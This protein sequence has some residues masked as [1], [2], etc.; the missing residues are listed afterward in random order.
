[1]TI[2]NKICLSLVI[3]FISNLLGNSVSAVSVLPIGG[4]S[5]ETAVLLSPGKYQGGALQGRQELY[6]IVQVKAGQKITAEAR[7][8]SEAGCDLFLFNESKEELMSN[9]G[10]NPKVSWLPNADKSSYNYYFKIANDYADVESFTVEV[11]LTNYY[12]ANSSTD[13]GATFESA[14]NLNTIP[15]S[16]TGYLSKA[17]YDIP[18]I[19]DDD[20]DLYRISVPKGIPYEFKLTP[21]TKGRGT[22][23]LYD[24]TRQLIDEK[25]SPNEGAFIS[26]FLI[27]AANTSVF[28]AVS[29]DWSR[30]LSAYK[31]D[32]KSS[33]PVT[34]FYVCKENYCELAGEYVSL[35]DCQTSTTKTCY[36]TE[37]CDDQC[38][39]PTSTTIVPPTTKPQN[40][41]NLNQTKC[42]DNFNYQKCDNYDKD[43]YLEWST[44]VY[45]GEGNKC[46]G[47]KCVKAKGCQCSAWVN[48]EC[49]RNNCQASEMYQTRTCDPKNCDKEEQCVIDA[50]CK[51]IPACIKNSDCLKG[52]ICKTGECI[53]KGVGWWRWFSLGF[54]G[55]FFW[56]YLILLFGLYIY[57]A[58]C[59]QFLAK[60]TNTPNGWL[61]WI[62]IADIFLMLQ[63]SQKPLWW[64]LLF[65]IPIVNI[66]IGIIIWMKIAE[67]VGKPNWIGVLSIVPV[68]GIA[69]PGYLAFSGGEKIEPIQ[70][71]SSIGTEAANKPTVGYKHPCKYCGKLIPPNSA[72]CPLCGKTNPQGPYRCPKCHEPI[73]KNWQACSHCGQ[74]LRIMC[75]KCGKITFFGDYCEDCNARLLVTCPHCNQEQPPL[76]DKCIKCDQPL[77][78][79]K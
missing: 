53:V 64:F 6:Y 68:I 55:W 67:R 42:F 31:L 30:D 13:A 73:E 7:G 17:F 60:K 41:C 21:P 12:D 37:N 33:V 18:S 10:E 40:E 78:T 61:A 74:N 39:S 50:T 48:K 4:D 27:P 5:F 70:P 47:G 56:L 22:L 76:G 52:F 75:P 26:L 9:Y 66:V 79:K 57:L 28:L 77:E 71:Y 63:I 45:C 32:I 29:G 2:K 69:I 44:P 58:L 23:A 16:Y 24:A 59:L 72:V 43:E 11:S 1:M 20:K 54:I 62:P 65:L 8:F 19:G 25:D 14:L 49:A 36:L 3:I 34:K 35:E 46:D 38:G 15:G 51:V